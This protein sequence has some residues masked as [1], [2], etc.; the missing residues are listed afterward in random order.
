MDYFKWLLGVLIILLLAIVALW[1]GDE[2]TLTTGQVHPTF[3]T[4]RSSGSKVVASE[5]GKWVGYLFGLLVIIIF[6]LTIFIGAK[7][8][9]GIGAIRYWLATGLLA[10]LVTYHLTVMA[11]WKYAASETTSYFGG[12]PSATAW[13]VYGLW[14]VPIIMTLV[15]VFKFDEWIISPQDIK[16]FEELVKED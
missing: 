4:M 2:P 10:Y 16:R 7:R 1:V 8:K 9:H 6:V 14:S 11:Y 13:M 15:Y 5:L 3:E 12:L